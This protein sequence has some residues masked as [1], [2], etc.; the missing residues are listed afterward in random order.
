[1]GTVATAHTV[2]AGITVL[3]GD[4]R[5]KEG[6]IYFTEA[7]YGPTGISGITTFSTFSGRAY[8]RLNYSCLLYTS[9]AADE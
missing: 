3:K 5:I 4:Y 2:G 6:V 9:D 8:Y 7:P 1:M